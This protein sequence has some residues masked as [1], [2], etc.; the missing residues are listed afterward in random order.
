M[1]TGSYTLAY[2]ILI[3]AAVV[4]SICMFAIKKSYDPLNKAYVPV[5]TEA[6]AK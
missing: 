4:G 1:A 6:A 2:A 3:P 5:K